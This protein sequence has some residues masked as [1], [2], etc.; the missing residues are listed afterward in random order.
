MKTVISEKPTELSLA[1][2]TVTSVNIRDILDLAWKKVN[3]VF[4]YLIVIGY[5]I[6]L[7]FY[8]KCKISSRIYKMVYGIG[9]LDF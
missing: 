6:K 2:A 1:V 5:L 7:M 8:W 4:Q 3:G 9:C